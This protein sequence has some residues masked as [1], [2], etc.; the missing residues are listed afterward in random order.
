MEPNTQVLRKVS[1]LRFYSLIITDLFSERT[2][3]TGL[4]KLISSVGWINISTNAFLSVKALLN[5][6]LINWSPSHKTNYTAD[7]FGN[8]PHWLKIQ[9]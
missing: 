8:T 3:I 6:K 1:M 9:L 5:S 7:E 4:R 2:A